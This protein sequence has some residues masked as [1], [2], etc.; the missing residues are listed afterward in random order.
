M[1]CGSLW[2]KSKARGGAKSKNKHPS[3]RYCGILEKWDPGAGTRDLGPIRGTGETELGIRDSSPGTQDPG[4]GTFTWDLGPGTLHLGPFLK[5]SH[6][7]ISYMSYERLR[8]EEQFR[9]KKYLLEMTPSRAKLR[10][11]SQPQKRNF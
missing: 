6:S 2:S 10:L 5:H 3:W 7:Y 9:S 1:F 8:G 4:S 11:K